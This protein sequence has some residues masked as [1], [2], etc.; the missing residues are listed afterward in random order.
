MNEYVRLS[1]DDSD[2]IGLGPLERE[3]RLRIRNEIRASLPRLESAAEAHHRTRTEEISCATADEA[4]AQR[5]QAA[6]YEAALV[7]WRSEMAA[8]IDDRIDA[9]LV[10]WV[11]EDDG[12]DGNANPI[13]RMLAE[14]VGRERR[15]RRTEVKTAVEELRRE[16]GD[17]L[18]SLREHVIDRALARPSQDVEQSRIDRA[19]DAA[20]WKLSAEFTALAE[21]QSRA[22][23]ARIADLEMRLRNATATLPPIRPWYSGAIGHEGEL[24]GFKGSVYQCGRTE[25]A[26][27]PPG[28]DWRLVAS[29][30]A[31][32]RDGR[33]LKARGKYDSAK[34]YQAFD[35]VEFQGEQFMSLRDNPGMC[36]GEAWFKLRGSKGERGERGERGLRGS[37]GPRAEPEQPVTIVNWLVEPERF[38]ASPLLSNGS[39]GVCLELRSLFE[40]YQ[41]QTS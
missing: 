7:R 40:M 22:Y 28:S 41:S 14:V 30:G 31:D 19:V 13:L 2:L 32:G 23:E 27:T 4:Q 33:S 5:E 10:E 37:R 29:A 16:I 24:W 15:D 6:Q 26:A 35:V 36:P 18:I 25:T 1:D 34:T 38:R 3:R 11:V 20:M 8:F 9:R 12:N 39:V 17:K 21:K